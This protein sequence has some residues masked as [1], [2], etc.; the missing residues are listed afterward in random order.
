MEKNNNPPDITALLSAARSGDKAAVDRLFQA[1]YEQLRALA[2]HR[3]QSWQGDETM[4][5]TALVHEAYLKLGGDQDISWKNRGHFFA[6][7][8]KVMRHILINYSRMR[9]AQKRGGTAED[10]PLEGIQVPD[11]QTAEELLGMDQAL[12]RLEKLS[13]RQ[14]Q[15]VECRFF[16]GLDV[17][18]TAQALDISESTVKRDWALASAW[19]HREMGVA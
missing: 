14:A 15:V 2:H 7:A 19:L 6:T 16:G 4:D 18:S 5:T 10:L 11:E 12:G 9:K 8:S 13:P 17:T 3:R 1:V